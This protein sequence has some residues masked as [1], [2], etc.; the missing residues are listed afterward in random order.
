M[1]WAAVIAASIR[2]VCR[3]RLTGHACSGLGYQKLAPHLCGWH[4]SRCQGLAQW[5]LSTD[6]VLAICQLLGGTVCKWPTLMLPTRPVS[7]KQHQSSWWLICS[8]FRYARQQL[9]SLDHAAGLL[10]DMFVCTWSQSPGFHQGHA[11]LPTNETICGG[12]QV[13][14]YGELHSDLSAE[15]GTDVTCA[16]C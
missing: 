10:Y 9:F 6:G 2:T 12:I 15:S 11:P 16:C 5:L 3:S 1:G 7:H 4:M 8:G 14:I 13:P